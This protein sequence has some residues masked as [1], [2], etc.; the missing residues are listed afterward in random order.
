MLHQ[1]DRNMRG[2]GTGLDRLQTANGF[3]EGGI[4]GRLA[5]RRAFAIENGVLNIDNEKCCG[6]GYALFLVS[7]K[8]CGQRRLSI[9]MRTASAPSTP[10]ISQR[11]AES[12]AGRPARKAA[13]EPAVST[14]RALTVTLVDDLDRSEDDGLKKDVP[15]RR[16][17]ELRQQRK[18]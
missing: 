1:N 12:Q 15:E 7:K 10:P 4:D 14:N 16:I 18:I 6:H 3:G 9:A 13:I 2:A 8:G 17:D 5:F 11:C